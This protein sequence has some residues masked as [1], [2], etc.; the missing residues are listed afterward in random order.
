LDSYFHWWIPVS[1]VALDP[2]GS[3]ETPPAPGTNAS[4]S[5]S[6]GIPEGLAGGAGTEVDV[7]A[8]VNNKNPYGF[9]KNSASNIQ[10]N[11]ASF[12]IKPHGVQVI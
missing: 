6:F 12:S 9:V 3:Y 11:V 4:S 10:G 1:Q 7:I 8:S 5:P 2:A